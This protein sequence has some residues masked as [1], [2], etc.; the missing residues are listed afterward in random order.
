MMGVTSGEDGEVYGWTTYLYEEKYQK[1]KSKVVLKNRLTGTLHTI[2]R[3]DFELDPDFDIH[4]HNNL[5]PAVFF[6]SHELLVDFIKT[7]V[8][9]ICEE[10]I[11]SAKK[12]YPRKIQKNNKKCP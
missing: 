8:I 11:A 6:T 2:S 7:G 5:C 1:K 12:L 4:K 3:K 10:K 9:K